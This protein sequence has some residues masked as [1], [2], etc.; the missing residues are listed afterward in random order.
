VIR[1]RLSFLRRD[2]SRAPPVA[3]KVFDIP[4]AARSLCSFDR[5]KS[6]ECCVLVLE[7]INPHASN[8]ADASPFSHNRKVS[9]QTPSDRQPVE[10][11][12][13][14]GRINATKLTFVLGSRFHDDSI[15]A[16]GVS[17]PTSFVNR[18]SS[19]DSWG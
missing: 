5:L 3:H 6:S 8:C 13:V 18:S 11:R 10:P 15:A 9:K 17:R 14:S 7:K 4:I 1:G 12:H 16:A 19:T 2:R